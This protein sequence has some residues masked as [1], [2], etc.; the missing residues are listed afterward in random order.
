[1][2]QL[3]DELEA[4]WELYRTDF[5]REMY[6]PRGPGAVLV[7][8]ADSV[9]EA[10]RRLGELP[11][12]SNEIMELELIELGPFGAFQR[13]FGSDGSATGPAAP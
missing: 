1:M 12:L 4:L 3:R 2:R 9:A 13:L 7:L 10:R 6:A 5:V 8:E 11:L